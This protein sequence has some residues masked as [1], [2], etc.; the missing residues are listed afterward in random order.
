MKIGIFY[1]CTGKYSIFWK[2]FFESC[3]QFFLPQ[4]EKKYYVFTDASDIQDTN[5]IKTYYK[6]SQGFPL[7]SIAI[8]YVY[9]GRRRLKRVRLR[10]FFQLKHGI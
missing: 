6:Q 10:L 1:I 4:V 8:W 2:G 5:N 3:E 9:W 7:D